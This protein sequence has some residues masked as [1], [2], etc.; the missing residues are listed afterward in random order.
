MPALALDHL[1]PLAVRGRVAQV[2]GLTVLV[3]DLPAPVGAEVTLHAARGR[4]TLTGEVVGF[5]RDRAVILP[6]GD[7]AGIACGD[8][9][10]VDR[11]AP[12]CPVGDALLGRVIDA[13][14]RP[15]DNL[16]PLLG[17]TRRPLHA[18]GGA[19]DPLNRPCIDTPLA[20]GARAVDALLPLGR[21]QRIG[22]FAGAGMGKS[23]LLGIMARHTAAD[24]SVIAL[25]GERGREVNDFIHKTLGPEGLARSVVVVATGDDPAPL[26][27][28]AALAA[29]TIAEAF[30]D[31]GRDVLL[32]M[33]SVTRFAQA[34]RQ[35]GLAA[36]EPPTTRGF[37]P[38]VFARLPV[39][40]ERAGRTS[41]GSITALYA[42]LTEGD[43][44][45]DP[46]ADACR[47][48]LDGHITLSRTLAERGHFPAIDL[49]RSISRVADDVTDPEHTAARR[50]VLKL[51]AAYREVEELLNI[52]A[53]AAGSNP[54]FDLAIAC[55]GAID[56]M[57]QQ[58]RGEHEGLGDFTR[59]RAQLVA[60]HSHIQAAKG[61]VQAMGKAP[62]R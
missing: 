24:V 5:D 49:N 4:L 23:T 7:T 22:V 17:C 32:L 39:L 56:A 46:I 45:T 34:Q 14:G 29:T 53:Y 27:I 33:D 62:K 59:T 19:V 15:I 20:T 40:L 12:L 48:I 54:L 38:S 35:V 51:T 50:E 55:K 13:T 57:T 11:H 43:E 60:L 16:G 47:S 31:D 26:R 9:V 25:V 8:A 6:L 36:G 61:Q 18:R 2:R 1:A 58:G 44:V 41:R 37:P 30:R 28:R 42:V 21:G 10:D 52:G 3:D